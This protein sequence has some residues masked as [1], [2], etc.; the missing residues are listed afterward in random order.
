MV[1]YEVRCFG[2][3]WKNITNCA[4]GKCSAAYGIT[5]WISNTHLIKKHS[6]VFIAFRVG[7]SSYYLAG[8]MISK[9]SGLFC[10]C[11]IGIWRAL[12]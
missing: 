12:V 6:C 5:F 2:L 4:S 10:K 3:L 9:T 11:S 8:R 1:Y 7:G